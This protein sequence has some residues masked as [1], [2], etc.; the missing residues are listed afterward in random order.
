MGLSNGW[1]GCSEGFLRSSPISPRKNPSFLTLLLGFTFQKGF[2]IGPPKMHRWFRIGLPKILRRFCIGPTKIHRWF[3]IGSP[4]VTLFF[5]PPE[6]YSQW[7]LCTMAIMQEKQ[8][9]FLFEIE[10]L[11]GKSQ[12]LFC[13]GPFVN[14]LPCLAKKL[15]NKPFTY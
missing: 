5:V 13:W 12:G 2:R 14:S 4:Q 10:C 8:Q 3:C 15:L 11:F 1:Q 6:F 9:N 7:I